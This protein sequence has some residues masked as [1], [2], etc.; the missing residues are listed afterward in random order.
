LLPDIKHLQ[1]NSIDD[2]QQITS[3]TAAV[4]I[5]PIQGEA[6][7]REANNDFLV[8]LRQTCNQYGALLIFDEIQTG[9]GR[10]GNLFAFEHYAVIPDILLVAKGMGGGLPIGAF[11]ASNPLMNCFTNNPVLGHINTFGGNAVCLAA[12]QAS[13]EI[14]T[15]EKLFL[16]A[17]E[18]ETI[19]LNELKH[20]L[21]KEIRIKG[22]LCAIDFG[23]EDLNFKIIKACLQNG[24]ITDWF[25]FCT[26]AMRLSPPLVISNEE[27]KN[28]ITKI[29]EIINKN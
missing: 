13:L 4:I 18:I 11:I 19:I 1:F 21:I 17:N 16:R 14:I 7:V 2:L 28:G 6:G 23:N 15:N 9:F 29:I 26:T 24:I 10:T 25:L 8:A 5:E 20:P 3:K 12:A 27:L 22:A